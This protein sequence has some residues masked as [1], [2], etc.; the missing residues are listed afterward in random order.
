MAEQICFYCAQPARPGHPLVWGDER[1]RPRRLQHEWTVAYMDALD[2]DP[3]G[4]I[5]PSL[6]PCLPL[7]DG[8]AKCARCDSAFPANLLTPAVWQMPMKDGLAWTPE[9]VYRPITDLDPGLYIR[10]HQ[11]LQEGYGVP[12]DGTLGLVFEG[13]AVCPGCT[14]DWPQDSQRSRAVHSSRPSASPSTRT[15]HQK[16]VKPDLA[17]I[18]AGLVPAEAPGLTLAGLA[19]TWGV[20]GRQASTVVKSLA[21]RLLVEEVTPARGGSPIKHYRRAE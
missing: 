8:W 3:A 12:P 1:E 6:V 9:A 20:T 14:T 17:S 2:V 7:R 13:Y 21:G 4:D 18:R 19:L 11:T 16:A 15:G 10:L 5:D